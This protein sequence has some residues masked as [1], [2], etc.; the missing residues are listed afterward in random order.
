MIIIEKI[1]FTCISDE[2]FRRLFDN[3]HMLLE[4]D[5]DLK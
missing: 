2:I 5:D 4:N 1:C 3:G